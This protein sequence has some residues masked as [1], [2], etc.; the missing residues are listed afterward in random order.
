MCLNSRFVLIR[1]SSYQR[2]WVTKVVNVYSPTLSCFM[3]VPFR[4]FVPSY[5]NDKTLKPLQV[6]P[7]DTVKQPNVVVV[8]KTSG[9][10]I[11]LS[12]RGGN[13]S[14][15]ITRAVWKWNNCLKGGKGV[16]PLVKYVALHKMC[17]YRCSAGR[18]KCGYMKQNTA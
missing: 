7:L 16:S 6:I 3:T 13:S 18:S 8:R 11:P 17:G 15:T 4:P 9:S 10:K 2:G 14:R 5:Q 1:P 12:N